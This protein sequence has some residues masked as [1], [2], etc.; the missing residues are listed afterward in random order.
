MPQ[1]IGD[2][3]RID[4]NL[5]F[6]ADIQPG[7]T[8][9]LITRQITLAETYD[10]KGRHIEL[11]ASNSISVNSA[12]ILSQGTARTQGNKYSPQRTRGHSPNSSTLQTYG[13]QFRHILNVR[14]SRTFDDFIS[15]ILKISRFSFRATSTLTFS[16]DAATLS[17]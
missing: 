17:E 2:V 12:S 14:F 1:I 10:L 3:I 4:A 9:R 8:L 16:I 13:Q 5:P 11:Y 15:L 7:D 6:I